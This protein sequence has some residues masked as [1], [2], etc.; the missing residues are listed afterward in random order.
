MNPDAF[1]FFD[2]NET[3]MTD[4]QKIE[5]I[6]ESIRS[7]L[8]EYPMI[9]ATD[10]LVLVVFQ[11]LK[12]MLVD[13]I[14]FV[15]V[16][17]PTGSGKSVIG[18][19][20]AYCFNYCLH[21]IYGMDGSSYLLTSSKMLQ[22]QIQEDFKRFSFGEDY[23]MLKGTANYPC[24]YMYF[25]QLAA[26]RSKQK[27]LGAAAS[28][29]ASSQQS[30]VKPDKSTITS[31]DKRYCIGLDADRKNSLACFPTCQYIVKR[32]AAS[33]A[34]CANLNYSYFLTVLNASM[35]PYFAMRNLTIADEAHLIP[36]I[37]CNMFSFEI[38]AA[39]ARRVGKVLREIRDTNSK[40]LMWGSDADRDVEMHLQFSRL[41][42][43]VDEWDT[44]FLRRNTTLPEL[45]DYV[46]WCSDAKKTIVSW[47]KNVTP[48]F[49]LK[50]G[51]FIGKFGE[52]E[53]D[54]PFPKPVELEEL[55]SRPN[56]VFMKYDESSKYG[57]YIVRDLQ[58]R[59]LVRNKFLSKTQFCLFLSATLGNTDQ[60]GE[61]LGIRPDQYKS[62]RMEPTFD[63]STS[64]IYQCN[65]GWLTYKNFSDNIDNCLDA[66]LYICHVLHPDE[67]GIIHT[68]TF[69]NAELLK[70][71]I[72]DY[73][74]KSDNGKFPGIQA[75]R[76]RFYR[77]PQEKDA[78]VKE[79]K[80]SQLPLV[81]VGPSLY[82]GLDLKYDEGRFNILL[83]V[84]YPGIDDYVRAKMERIPFWY[85]RVTIEKT[86]QAIGRTNR[87]V[88]D[89]STTYL[90]DS[91][92]SKIAP[93]MLGS[94]IQER[95]E[96]KY[97]EVP[98]TNSKP[99]KMYSFEAQNTNQ[100]TSVDDLW[101][102]DLPF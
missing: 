85:E 17:A 82:E 9:R 53:T 92:F 84:P 100:N 56:D 79:L 97:L 5:C 94:K 87:A 59:E 28:A 76:F 40:D 39:T 43:E 38:S 1:T 61:L 52:E 21:T 36:D 35:N 80:Q 71:K 7:F 27:L 44:L 33:D 99:K 45:I 95:L 64:P 81:I 12:N 62:Y 69:S 3:D 13:K 46:R 14:R 55:A 78:C 15:A 101:G 60:Y 57:K 18:Y 47:N 77:T 83:K 51:G 29:F 91:T 86:I 16:E 41:I 49:K 2:E 22:K 20:M 10:T 32:K 4:A 6:K 89:R 23:A 75:S 25:E 74:Y 63:Y 26:E 30:T 90:I 31:Y 70:E 34:M 19:C 93:K 68:S 98:Q 96:R 42:T 11:A 54:A 102:D 58:E 37:V 66:V 48:E 73:M 72:F 65:C 67:K 50:M 88:D 24:T 8:K